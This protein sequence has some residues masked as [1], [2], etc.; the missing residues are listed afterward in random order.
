[1]NAAML[2]DDGF[3]SPSA[4]RDD[5]SDAVVQDGG[6][7]EQSGFRDKLRLVSLLL[8]QS[9]AVLQI[10]RSGHAQARQELEA[11]RAAYRRAIE[12]SQAGRW[13]SAGDA[14]DAAFRRVISATHMA[15][16]TVPAMM[17]E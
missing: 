13:N 15:L 5:A 4:A 10:A 17:R 7:G 8:G 2:K 12:E 3:S 9:P 11:A 6:C 1:M 14:L 16:D